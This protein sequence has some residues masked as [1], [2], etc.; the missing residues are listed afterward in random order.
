MLLSA[1]RDEFVFHCQCRKLSPH[2]IRNQSRFSLL[3]VDNIISESN[4][5]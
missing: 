3:P 1:I 2:T 5:M 4:R